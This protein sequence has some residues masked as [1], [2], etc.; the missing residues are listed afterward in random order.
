MTTTKPSTTA[1]YFSSS[2]RVGVT[3]LRSSAKT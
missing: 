1:V 2:W 3:T